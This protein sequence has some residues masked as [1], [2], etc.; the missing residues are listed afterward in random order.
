MM[1]RCV[2]ACGYVLTE[3]R[4]TR[5]PETGATD[6]INWTYSCERNR[7]WVFWKNGNDS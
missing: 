2:S 6:T 4:S 1:N 5:S 3:A 7:V